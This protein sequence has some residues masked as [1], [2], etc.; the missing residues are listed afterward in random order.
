MPLSIR[1]AV[2]GAALALAMPAPLAAQVK[3]HAI[4]PA[5]LSAF[6][7]GKGLL[8][9]D[10]TTA[11]NVALLTQMGT[12]KFVIM[13]SGCNQP[14]TRCTSMQFYAGFKPKVPTTAA[15]INEWNR[16]KRYSRAYLD[17]VN[18]PGIEMD[19]SA[20][21]GSLSETM[22]QDAYG[23]WQTLLPMFQSTVFKGAAPVAAKP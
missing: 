12:N 3:T 14:V 6:L 15:T 23:H 21:D 5:G 11:T 8:V 20:P 19:V 16:T 1:S 17:T 4:T 13:F 18:D 2:A 7:R 9:E 22:L 10:R